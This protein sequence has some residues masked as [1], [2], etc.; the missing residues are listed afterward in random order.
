MIKID[1]RDYMTARDQAQANLDLARAQL[2]SAKINLEIVRV[3]AP[4]NL[5]QAHVTASTSPGEPSQCGAERMSAS[6]AWTRVQRRRPTPIRPILN[7]VPRTRASAP[8]RRRSKRLDWS[9]K[10]FEAAEATVKQ[11]EA[12]VAQMQAAFDAS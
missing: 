4:A 6:T 2:A 11:Q 7:C 3:S 1:P 8:L 9:R 5:V 12:Q 10:T